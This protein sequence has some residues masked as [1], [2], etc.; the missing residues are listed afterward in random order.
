MAAATLAEGTQ[1]KLQPLSQKHLPAV[2]TLNSVIFPVKYHVWSNTL[3]TLTA[4]LVHD[5]SSCSCMVLLLA[6][7]GVPGRFEMWSSVPA[8]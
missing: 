8:G 6:G 3:A 4:S 7:P 5:I 1:I 2:Q